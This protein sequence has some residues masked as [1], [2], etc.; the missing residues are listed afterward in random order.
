HV[1]QDLCFHFFIVLHLHLKLHPNSICSQPQLQVTL[2]ARVLSYDMSAKD[3]EAC[4]LFEAQVPIDDSQTVHEMET[5]P[6][7]DGEVLQQSPSVTEA[8][9]NDV[10]EGAPSPVIDRHPRIFRSLSM[11]FIDSWNS[12]VSKSYH[13][14]TASSL[15][16][17][18]ESIESKT[19]A[20][21]PI[22]AGSMREADFSNR[23][24]VL[25]DLL[26]K[27]A[28]V[29]EDIAQFR[30]EHA[31]MREEHA[32][33]KED[34][35]N[36]RKENLRILENLQRRTKDL[37]NLEKKIKSITNTAL[38]MFLVE[39]ILPIV[40]LVA[41]FWFR[42]ECIVLHQAQATRYSIMS[43]NN[44]K[45][46]ATRSPEVPDS[47]VKQREPY[48]APLDTPDTSRSFLT[49]SQS[50]QPE[51]EN[52]NEEMQ[53]TS[54]IQNQPSSIEIPTSGAPATSPEIPVSGRPQ[55]V[56]SLVGF[57][58]PR[59]ES[60]SEGPQSTSDIQNHP[61][62]LEI[63]SSRD[64]GTSPEIPVSGRPE[65]PTTEHR[66]E[67]SSGNF[68]IV[69]RYFHQAVLMMANSRW[70]LRQFRDAV[71]DALSLEPHF[72]LLEWQGLG[73][74]TV[75]WEKTP[76]VSEGFAAFPYETM[77]TVRN[78]RVVLGFLKRKRGDVVSVAVEMKSRER[79]FGE[80]SDMEME[81]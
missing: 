35:A 49:S 11:S 5:I 60:S 42:L 24:R 28:K 61:S 38:Y 73:G 50:G 77:I 31:E 26:K 44:R 34:Q 37:E 56:P 46:K 80:S 32:Q 29:E 36:M 15:T 21:P 66:V 78:L 47:Q 57:N 63:P 7:D 51:H 48:T 16:R 6:R 10:T 3:T 22:P 52:T 75:V 62:S 9:Q 81:T 70:T 43:D 41:Y 2:E 79:A 1:R 68:P 59:H 74:F 58:Q 65:I 27:H 30:K 14:S 33:I 20:E 23:S 4:S 17:S 54:E 55:N 67:G 25:M 45:R 69:L 53:L 13:L 18:L 76:V 72:E 40:N 64:V 39:V 19:M 8:G 12:Q 71:M